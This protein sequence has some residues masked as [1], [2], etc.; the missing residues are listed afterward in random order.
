LETIRTVEEATIHPLGALEKIF[1]RMTVSHSCK[2]AHYINIV[3]ALVVVAVVLLP[4]VV[5]RNNLFTELPERGLG[6]TAHSIALDA[7]LTDAH[8]GPPIGL[9]SFFFCITFFK[10]HVLL[11][12]RSLITKGAT[13]GVSNQALPHFLQI[14]NSILRYRMESPFG[15]G[16]KVPRDYWIIPGYRLLLDFTLLLRRKDATLM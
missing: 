5:L 11:H 7:F 14:M 2:A 4:H 6:A 12:K 3:L 13:G 8:Q 10:V 9:V 15:R 16:T 1:I